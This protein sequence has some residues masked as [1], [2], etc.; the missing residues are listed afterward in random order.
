MSYKGGNQDD[1]AGA[2]NKVPAWNG[3]P[4][5]FFHFTQEVK[6]FL[7][8]TKT[9]ERA[10]AAA[11]LVRKLLESDYPALRSLMYRLDPSEFR[12]EAA[13][14]RL[15]QFLEASPMNKQPIPD[16][17]AKLSAYY[18]K[19]ARR[20][21]ETI[22][23]FLIREE[24]LHD[25]M[26][27]ALQ[28]LL[29]EKE[30]DFERYD[31]TMAELKEFCG[32]AGDASV[33][34]GGI[35]EQESTRT[36]T[37][38]AGS[39]AASEQD[40]E[41]QRPG[42]S[43]TRSAT[44]APVQRKPLDMIQRLMDKG[45]VP[46]AAL[47]IIRGWMVLE[48]ASENDTEKTLVKA[49]A[50]NKLGYD[51]VRRALLTLHEDRGKGFQHPRGLRHGPGK[52]KYGVMYAIDEEGDVS[53]EGLDEWGS[54]QWDAEWAYWTPHEEYGSVAQD[55]YWVEPDS[56]AEENNL[57]QDEATSNPQLEEAMQALAKLQ[58]EE[59]DLQVYMADAQRNLE[60][61]RKAVA[62]A[63]RDRG[64][65]MTSAS[66][67]PASKP[68]STWMQQGKGVNPNVMY[69]NKGNKG[70][71]QDPFKG[72]K[73]HG[74]MKGKYASWMVEPQY[75]MM[76]MDVLPSSAPSSFSGTPAELLQAV[77]EQLIYPT[78]AVLDTGATVSA[79]GEAAVNALISSLAQVRPDM[80]LT[81]VQQDRPYFR[82][83]SGSWGQA[84]Y[85]V[86][87]DIPGQSFKL[88]FY[89]LPS[90]G[91]P[92]LLG[93][94]EMRQLG[95]IIN[96]DTANAIVLNKPW[97]LRV[98]SKQQILMDM[99]AVVAEIPML[100]C[101][102]SV[103]FCLLET[104]SHSMNMIEPND[105]PH[106]VAVTS[107]NVDT[108]KTC[109]DAC[110]DR[111]GHTLFPLQVSD[112][113]QLHHVEASV[114]ESTRP[115][116][117]FPD[118]ILQKHLGVNSSDLSFLLS[119]SRS[120][121]STSST[122]SQPLPGF[123][124]DGGPLHAGSDRRGHQADDQGDR[125][126]SRAR[127][128]AGDKRAQEQ[129]QEGA[130]ARIRYNQ[131]H[132]G[133]ERR[134]QNA[135]DSMAMLQPTCGEEWRQSV[136][137]LESMRPMR[138]ASDLHTQG[139]CAGEQQA[140]RVTSAGHCCAG[141]PASTGRCA[142]GHG[143]QACAQSDQ[144]HRAG[145]RAEGSQD[146]Q[147][148]AGLLGQGPRGSLEQRRNEEEA[149]ASSSRCRDRLVRGI[150]DGH[151]DGDNTL[152]C[153]GTEAA[154][155]P[156]E[157]SRPDWPGD[158]Q[159][160]GEECRPVSEQLL[161]SIERSLRLPVFQGPAQSLVAVR[162]ETDP[163]SLWEVCCGTNSTLTQEVTRNGFRAERVSLQTGFDLEKRS[164]VQK[165]IG[166]IPEKKP[167]KIWASPRCTPWTNSQNLNQR[168]PAQIESLRRLRYRSRRQVRHL[169]QIF[170]AV[171]EYDNSNDVY[172]E[173]P[174]AAKQGWDLPEWKQFQD[175]LW[176]HFQRKVFF[177]KIDGCMVG[178]QNGEGVP[179]RKQWTI[180]T[181]DKYFKDH[182]EVTCQG[183]HT[184]VPVIGSGRVVEKSGYY[185]QKFAKRIVQVWK[186]ALH[187]DSDAS[188]LSDVHVLQQ[189]LEQLYPT[190]ATTSSSSSATLPQKRAASR[191]PR[192]KG[193]MADAPPGPAIP[194]QSGTEPSVQ[195]DP[196]P[197]EDRVLEE[198]RQKGVALLHRLHKAAG[199]PSNKALVR[200]CRDRK[201]AKW[202]IEEAERLVCQ[203]CVDAERGG[204][205]VVQKSLGQQP[206]PWQMVGIDV[207]EVA[208]PAQ[209]CKSRFLIMTCLAMRFISLVHLW[210]GSFSDTG[211]DAGERIINAFCK[212][213]LLHRPRPEWIVVDSQ[214]SL[215]FGQF[216]EFLEH[217]GIGLT[218][219][220]GEAHWC[221]GRT[222]AMVQVA[223]R[224]MRRLRNEAPD[225]S[226]QSLATLVVN[227][228]NNSDKVL[229]Y[230]PTQWAYGYDPN[231][232]HDF[233]DPLEA[234]KDCMPGPKV[235]QDMVKMRE[236]AEQINREERA[237]ESYTRL[238]NSA[239]RPLIDYRIGDFVCVWRSATLKARKRD[240]EYNPEP[241]FIGPGRIV[242][243]EPAILEGRK[244]GVIWVLYGTT[245]YRCATEQLRPATS[246]EVT[247]EL[248][249]GGTAVV[250]PK[251]EL[252]R[253]LKTYVDV[254]PE[255]E[256]AK[257]PPDPEAERRVRQR[258]GDS[259]EDLK[260][261]WERL[262]AMN[263][264]RRTDGLP[265][266]LTLPPQPMSQTR[267]A[268]SPEIFHMD[269]SDDVLPEEA[270]EHHNQPHELLQL[271]RE[272]IHQLEQ[273][274]EYGKETDLLRA[275]VERE[276]QQELQLLLRLQDEKVRE[277]KCFVIE[278][279][280]HNEDSLI[281][282]PLMYT[283]H[284]LESKGAEVNY[285]HL[286]SDEC[287][288][289]DEAKAR[290]LSEVAGSQALRAVQSKEE[291]REALANLDRHI[292]MRWVLTWKPLIPPEPPEPG[293]PTTVDKS[294]SKKAKA[295]V[296]L[297]GFKHPDLVKRDPITGKPEL[298]TASPTI[299][300]T[301][302]NLL[303]QAIAFDKHFLESAD[304]KSAFLQADNREE[305]RR[306]WTR[307][308][309]ELARSLGM[310]EAR[311]FRIMGA[312][313]GLTNAPRIFWK[314]VD[315]KFRNIGAIPHAL[316]RC[317]WLFPDKFGKIC[318][319]AGSQVDDFL[320]GGDP[321]S[322]CWKKYREKIQQMYRW[323]PWQKSDFIYSG[324]RIKQMSNHSIFLSQEDFCNSVRPVE[325][326]QDR[327]RSDNDQMSSHELSQCRALIMKCQW[328][329]IQSAP[330]Y[331][332]R[333]GMCTS[334]LKDNCLRNL[335]EANSI[336][337][338]LR[339]SAK[340]DL[341]FHNFHDCQEVDITYKDVIF[342]HWGDAGHKNRPDHSSTGGYVTGMS[343]PSIMHGKESPVSI[344]DWRSWKLR[345]PA[346]GT[347]SS[348]GQA[349]CEAENK[350]W[351]C[352]LFWALLHGH[353]LKHGQADVLTS[354]FISLLITDSRGCYDMLA[355][356]ES[357]GMAGEDA[358]TS[359]D[360]LSAKHGLRDGTQCYL[361][362]VPGEMNLSDALT[363][364][365]SEAFKV[366]ALY[367]ERKSWIIRFEQEFVSA[368]KQ[369][370]L[371]R[372]KQRLEEKSGLHFADLPEF[373]EEDPWSATFA[374]AYHR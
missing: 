237:R 304:A 334:A 351:R 174:T 327:S 90:P 371:R 251:N 194:A 258:R 314:D 15:I 320:L 23:Q 343:V 308:V 272:R 1:K 14:A 61:A 127:G 287:E 299:S 13:I 223:K 312:V 329:A 335:R 205:G 330:Q 7:A 326:A 38:P 79:G 222:E 206:H 65:T 257:R 55:Y 30:L 143:W 12:D 267:Q 145:V 263:E 52:G 276:H 255:A 60:Q 153:E 100:S 75:Q 34:Y 148:E 359:V 67:K 72:K 363:K 196:S 373:W 236:R 48:M 140:K 139:G 130:N 69:F 365:T 349:I 163:I 157:G 108:G 315:Y 20:S 265:P 244:E 24:T 146:G 85:K 364:V 301:G 76:T 59:K 106:S 239:P 280:I 64:W 269:E 186:G 33:Y 345:R 366:M 293:K 144:D 355:S 78:E 119:K 332:A 341:V 87:I 161:R 350:G 94:R 166:S 49:S 91:V 297:I 81:I 285:R 98:N 187:Q 286:K 369:Q 199:H 56:N 331:S 333:I 29:R 132:E 123:L 31:V 260:R 128:G 230:S 122:S 241:R 115:H 129:E 221:H 225:L 134:P 358:K 346:I 3:S 307:G 17:G 309:P 243:I 164:D 101:G 179:I 124:S 169:I 102:R 253:R 103:A 250:T 26:W 83:G 235:F 142:R 324:C 290:E 247:M 296:V 238:V 245:L 162:Q 141:A 266:L 47:D 203:A 45:L 4:E 113:Q 111:D 224:T 348:E 190:T 193:H 218:V 322:P 292:P 104:D 204:H 210:T 220:P 228:H 11:R 352:R 283:K 344:L 88:Q 281:S 372:E 248:I 25:E 208:F 6:W 9:S 155:D 120:S 176:K 207:L 353:E 160:D 96:L 219:V 154:R 284:V 277:Q 167:R 105:V 138:C 226:P 97:Q 51:S 149:S 342:L 172:F 180:M 370:R 202:L 125:A 259:L 294:G 374:E 84:S 189:D 82:F 66:G 46:L 323:S 116:G 70:Y 27:R 173:W 232:D 16:A 291:T 73:G 43:E 270:P 63:K 54:D 213:W 133:R 58:E 316:D 325:I 181:T 86:N 152:A 288:L 89:A 185:P 242:L 282:N 118:R 10:Y 28:R 107:T 92:V 214:S 8:G 151:G 110:G 305:G 40:E 77:P 368:R 137:R 338:E 32:I 53:G 356:N 274:I 147:E 114:A 233:E 99:K 71:H 192:S 317:V 347:N 306:L 74:K 156:E 271:L 62:A 19:L 182:A 22:P 126:R 337:K 195:H 183:G 35:G 171:L 354:M 42:S 278:F 212:G 275:Q 150:G 289:F 261:S 93:M 328:R 44:P 184:H 215:R 295:R 340:E 135:G 273:K 361:T 80:N 201:L 367:H 254:V 209:K 279:D 177:C 21:G 112:C 159:Q 178:L 240:S 256:A 217:A 68:T 303:L 36:T 37:P 191:E 321:S 198:Q 339:K 313:Y 131:N 50:Q 175:W 117:L 300:R 2:G 298:A 310:P 227:A 5:T 231:R 136:R 121:N 264:A 319:R 252:L 197:D 170:K 18:R 57:E 302:R 41:E 95:I 246:P 216:P 211:T 268:S 311:L 188:I 39:A 249:K 168:T 318:G 362:W 234:N 336:A 360:L 262:V 229:G 357:L 200:L 165:L 158:G 109:G